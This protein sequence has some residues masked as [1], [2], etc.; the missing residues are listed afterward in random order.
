M[1]KYKFKLKGRPAAKGGTKEYYIASEVDERIASLLESREFYELMQSYRC[2][3]I[4]DQPAV[5]AA[6]E[7]VKEFIRAADKPV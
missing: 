1:Q 2:A 4:V 7:A 5:I 3:P 6:F